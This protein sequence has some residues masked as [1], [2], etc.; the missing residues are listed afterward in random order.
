MSK[1]MAPS[2]SSSLTAF[3][4]H[5]D[6]LK[7]NL[8]EAKSADK[9]RLVLFGSS[10]VGKSTFLARLISDMSGD[11]FQNDVIKRDKEENYDV[12]VEGIKIGSKR[13]TSTIVPKR[14]PL[15]NDRVIYDV[16]GFTD[17]DPNTEQVIQLMHRCM[18]SKITATMFVI[19][20][21]ATEFFQTNRS[22]ILETEYTNKLVDIFGR[23]NFKHNINNNTIF[24]VTQMD[25]IDEE[26][27]GE[28]TFK[29]MVGDI[30]DDA[31]EMG[32]ADYTL[33]LRSL[34]KNHFIV[35]YQN[36]DASKGGKD[37]FWEKYEKCKSSDSIPNTRFSTDQN[38][39]IIDSNN[40]LKLSSTGHRERIKGHDALVKKLQ[41][42]NQ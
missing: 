35:S 26:A 9:E 13:M 1:S 14:Y 12:H 36:W 8:A 4:K 39:M 40:G 17:S 18:L 2:S 28:K 19:V 15:A 38:R 6:E 22:S 3:L 42:Q 20:V 16:P 10:G 7:K 29:E 41:A 5:H 32:K 37:S 27:I 21:P 25:L 33:F 31:S 23:E 30:Q 34:K 11:N 24:V